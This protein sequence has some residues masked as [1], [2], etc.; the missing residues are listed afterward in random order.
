[1]SKEVPPDAVM[2]FLSSLFTLLDELNDQYEVYKVG[3]GP[4]VAESAMS[5]F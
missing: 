3:G 5:P 1:M 2:A 4:Q